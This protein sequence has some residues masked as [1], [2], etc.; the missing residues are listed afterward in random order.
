MKAILLSLICFSTLACSSYQRPYIPSEQLSN[1][2][3]K[4][5][6]ADLREKDLATHSL[7]V[8]SRTRLTYSND[9]MTMRHAINLIKPDK[10]RIDTLPQAAAFTLSVFSTRDLDNVFIDSTKKEALKSLDG[11]KLLNKT[12]NI[13]LSLSDAISYLT[14]TIPAMLLDEGLTSERL[15]GYQ[16]SNGDYI[17]A[18]DDL[19]YYW[20]IDKDNKQLKS[21]RSYNKFN[22]TLTFTIDYRYKQDGALNTLE[23][24]FPRYDVKLLMIYSTPTINA[25]SDKKLFNVDIPEGYKVFLI[26]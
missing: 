7:K 21:F 18:W 13:P 6:A 2:E 26:K 11:D 5:L 9:N 3:L 16:D 10:L 15:R 14:G 8:I 25:H 4:Q 22:R 20:T 23:L 17:M 24:N 19:R 1:V 12:L